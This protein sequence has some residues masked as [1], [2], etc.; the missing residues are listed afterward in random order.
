MCACLDCYFSSDR[1]TKYCAFVQIVFRLFLCFLTKLIESKL[2]ILVHQV[3]Q[4]QQILLHSWP[5]PWP[6]LQ[7][8]KKSSAT[9]ARAKNGTMPTRVRAVSRSSWHASQKI[10]LHVLLFPASID[11]KFFCLFLALQWRT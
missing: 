6:R 4:W 9:K 5:T 2:L 3:S 8:K 11:C 10:C 7:W 1:K